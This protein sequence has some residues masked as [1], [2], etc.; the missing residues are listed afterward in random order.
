VLRTALARP[1]RARPDAWP[2]RPGREGAA[3]GAAGRMPPVGRAG[4]S[5]LETPAFPGGS[6]PARFCC[7]NSRVG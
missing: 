4:P 6:S 2:A 7:G 1:I 5:N 3:L